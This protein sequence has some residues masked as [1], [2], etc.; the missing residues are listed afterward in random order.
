M[1]TKK[2]AEQIQPVQTQLMQEPKKPRKKKIINED[3]TCDLQKAAE[4]V[5]SGRG[6]PLSI[7]KDDAAVEEF[8]KVVSGGTPVIDYSA[9]PKVESDKTIF[10]TTEFF[11]VTGG[12]GRPKVETVSTGV[13][14]LFLIFAT[15]FIMSL[16]VSNVAAFK[17]IAIGPWAVPAA[18]LLFPILYI[19]SDVIAEVYGFKSAKRVVFIGFALNLIAVLYFQLVIVLKSPVWFVGSEAFATVL[20]NTPRVLVASFV[21]YLI[22]SYFNAMILS[23]M[24]VHS[25]NGKGFGLRAITSTIVGEGLDAFIFLF[26]AFYGTMPTQQLVTSALVLWTLKV[27]YEVIVL[28]ITSTVVKAVKKFE[29]IDTFDYGTSYNLFK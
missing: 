9:V 5:Q 27:I 4:A 17:M 24:K 10:P 6:K 18:T 28:P 16:I 2:D 25:K 7:D 14:W 21:A 19:M 3:T 15:L 12:S 1:A 26:I 13:S 29:G 11:P 23:V 22:G 20:G 8:M